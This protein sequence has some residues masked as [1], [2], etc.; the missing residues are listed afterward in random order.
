[1]TSRSRT[2]AGAGTEAYA[3]LAARLEAAQAAHAV[4]FEQSTDRILE[5]L[6]ELKKDV[7]RVEE[8]GGKLEQGQ[9]TLTNRVTD[10]ERQV[11][12]TRDSMQLAAK[13]VQPGRVES[14]RVAISAASKSPTARVVAGAA[15]FTALVAAAKNVPEFVRNLEYAVTHTYLWLKGGGNG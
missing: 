12:E 2:P 4:R 8:H 7:E 5:A 13:V 10:I 9:H 3:R 6:H 1:M 15:V 11:L 14:A